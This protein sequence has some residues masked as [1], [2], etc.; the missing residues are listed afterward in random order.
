MDVKKLKY[1]LGTATAFV[2]F[3]VGTNPENEK[4][5]YECVQ[6][7]CISNSSM[8]E[9]QTFKKRLLFEGAV[10]QELLS[11]DELFKELVMINFVDCNSKDIKKYEE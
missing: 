7:Y 8:F 1:T 11:G 3:V 6:N 10:E 9:N 4:V 5:Y 2:L